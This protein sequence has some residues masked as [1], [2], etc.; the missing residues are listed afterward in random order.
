VISLFGLSLY[1]FS[2]EINQSRLDF[3]HKKYFS[4]VLSELCSVLH[5][6]LRDSE[7]HR[8][9]LT[10][11]SS[12]QELTHEFANLFDGEVHDSYD[13]LTDELFSSIVHCYLST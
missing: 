4:P 13:L 2:I 11:E 1:P 10:I 9:V 8:S 7:D 6:S 3:V 5:L 12:T